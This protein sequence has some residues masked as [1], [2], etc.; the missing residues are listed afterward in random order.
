MIL[1]ALL[2]GLP[3]IA[4]VAMALPQPPAARRW[5]HRL[6]N[7][8][9]LALALWLPWQADAP[10]GLFSTAPLPVLA[11]ILVA[12]AG[13][14]PGPWG[15]D[16]RPHDQARQGALLLAAL[17]EPRLLAVMA[18]ALA[19]T[20]ALARAGAGRW[21]RVRLTG[22]GLSLLLYGTVTLPSPAGA[23]CVLLGLAALAYAVPETLWVVLISAGG[24]SAQAGPML[25]GMGLGTVL[26][27][28]AT[29]LIHP[30]PGVRMRLVALGQ[31]GAV[32][33]AFGLYTPQALFAG[34]VLLVLLAL[35]QAACRLAKP[36]STA[37]LAA[38]AG[39]AGIPP[40]G[41]FPGLVLL[42]VAAAG[43]APWLLLPLA[44]GLGGLGWASVPRL[45]PPRSSR[46][47]AMAGSDLRRLSP[48]WLP[49]LVAF[50]AG[51]C[52]P[53]PAVVWLHA[54]AECIR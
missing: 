30:R 32:A 7:L 48:A 53:E 29:L 17:A 46:S 41:V 21:D 25:I 22:V 50:L 40:F 37:A 26:I 14:V 11:A 6:V 4:A 34:V 9:A 2:I 54:A 19:V 33:V 39:L 12:G 36:R 24:L 27:C 51:F 42:L 10:D 35:S 5:V 20:A 49:L 47:A 43:S 31:G 15:G 28:A 18:L 3:F 52:L 16:A 8:A 23:G 38:A 45:A 1:P 13:C 44:V